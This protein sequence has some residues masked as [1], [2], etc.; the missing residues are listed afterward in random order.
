M[1]IT[2]SYQRNMTKYKTNTHTRSKDNKIIGKRSNKAP[3]TKNNDLRDARI[4]TKQHTTSA[5][6]R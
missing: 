1:C 5:K 3:N 2:M 6:P 4:Q